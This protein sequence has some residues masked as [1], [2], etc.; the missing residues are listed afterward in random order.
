M[1]C[2]VC[3]NVSLDSV[4][5]PRF[6]RLAVAWGDKLARGDRPFLFCR[7]QITFGDEKLDPANH[8][9]VLQEMQ[10]QKVVHGRNVQDDEVANTLLMRP[11]SHYSDRFEYLTFS[12][13]YETHA[14]VQAK[15]NVGKDEIDVTPISFDGV[16]YSD[17]V[18][19]PTLG[20]LAVD[21]RV[22]DIHLG[23]KAAINRLKSVLRAKDDGEISVIFDAT[24]QEVRKA[25]ET[26]SLTKFRF[27]IRPNNPRPVSRLAAELSEQM[28]RDGIGE[29]VAT[30]KPAGIDMRMSDEGLIRAAT[31]LIEAGYGQSSVS[32]FTE[33][34]LEAEIKKPA[35]SHDRAKNER[36]Q[37]RPREL[38][39]FVDTADV[40]EDEILKTAAVS[41]IKFFT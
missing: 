38:R 28:K 7:Y 6:T 26:W 19:V 12:A 30:A 21:D 39:V 16:K 33:D 15:Y 2:C 4:L 5:L 27:T 41:L 8:F 36:A 24:P 31:D 13:G 35:F 23:G 32:G 34:G 20:V 14:T 3:G 22:S 11:R 29:L 1:R 9:T 17:F 25:L 37:E 40:N 18:A 10:G